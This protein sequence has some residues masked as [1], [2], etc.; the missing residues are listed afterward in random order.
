MCKHRMLGDRTR[1]SVNGAY[2]AVLVI[3][4]FFVNS[5]LCVKLYSVVIHVTGDNVLCEHPTL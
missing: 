2:V 3:S 1:L 5:V 4:D